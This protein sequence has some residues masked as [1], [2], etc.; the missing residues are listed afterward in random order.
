MPQRCVTAHSHVPA[1]Q[2]LP[3]DLQPAERSRGGFLPRDPLDSAHQPK[4]LLAFPPS[5]LF[6][7]VLCPETPI[8]WL[9]PPHLQITIFWVACMHVGRA[10]DKAESAGRPT[11]GTVVRTGQISASFSSQ[12]SCGLS[13]LWGKLTKL[14]LQHKEQEE[15]GKG[16]QGQGSCPWAP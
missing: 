13:L 15:G 3:A 1:L 12:L 10:D 8:L 16:K 9:A 6:L 2:L 4:Q 7:V 11:A 5:G 14:T